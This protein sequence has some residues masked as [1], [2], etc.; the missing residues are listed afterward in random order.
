[1]KIGEAY[2]MNMEAMVVPSSKVK[3]SQRHLTKK[4]KKGRNTHF[5][6]H[7]LTPA[8]RWSSMVQYQVGR[9]ASN[10]RTQHTRDEL[11]HT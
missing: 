5:R 11:K 2:D 3:I 10:L 4:P 6:K 1:M 9:F 7:F 8:M